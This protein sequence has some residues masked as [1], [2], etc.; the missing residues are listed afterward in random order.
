MGRAMAATMCQGCDQRPEGR[1]TPTA[2]SG[3]NTPS[4]VTSFEPVARMPSVRQL[5]W[6]FTPGASNGIMK[7]S[8]VGPSSGSS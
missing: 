8:T 4:S 3:T 6:I 2:A 5:S 1:R 7:W